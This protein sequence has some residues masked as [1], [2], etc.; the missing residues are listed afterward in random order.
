MECGYIA[1]KVLHDALA[2]GDTTEAA[3]APYQ[4]QLEDSFVIKESYKNR[5][6]RWAF[7]EQSQTAR[8]AICLISPRV[9][10]RAMP[11]WVCSRLASKIPLAPL[12]MVSPRYR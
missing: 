12:P 2:K 7:I 9:S 11:G 5:Y 4:Q 10:T 1:A 3:L 8:T 6:F